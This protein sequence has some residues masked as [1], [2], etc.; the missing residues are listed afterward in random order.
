MN[1]TRHKPDFHKLCAPAQNYNRQEVFP[2]MI[3]YFFLGSVAG[4][5]WEVLIMLITEPHFRN[6]GFFSGPGLPI[7]GVG[8]VILYILLTKLKK[9][10]VAV[11]LLSAAIGGLWELAMG[12]F[13]DAVWGLRY[14]NYSGLPFQ[15]R[16]YVCLW[17]VLGFGAAG[18]L[19]VC[20]LSGFL[21]ER[22]LRLPEHIRR[23][24]NTLLALLFLIDCAAALI[25]PNTGRGI[26]F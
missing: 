17:S 15:F 9:H 5:F 6:R 19:W 25:F 7:Y 22:W 16:G 24:A 21:T 10:P 14:W 13:L 1:H 20:F 26:T 8:A 11:C 4:F 12:W 2:R 23:G 18:C 3:F